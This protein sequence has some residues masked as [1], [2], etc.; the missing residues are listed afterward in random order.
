MRILHILEELKPS[1]AE[2]MLHAA[3]PY[4]RE[5]G[6]Q[7]DILS[8][9]TVP[10]VY[11]Q[12]LEHAGYQIHHIPFTP[13]YAFL[14]AVY[15]FLRQRRYD[16]VH[17]HLERANFWYALLAYSSGTTKVAYTIH[18]IFP[19]NGALRIERSVQRWLM[20]NVI[21]VEMVTVSLSGERRERERFGN[22][23]SVI[24][25]WFE[26]TKYKLPSPKER[27]VSRAG[28]GIASD[29]T[30]VTSIGGC[31]SY[32]NH[33]SIVE[34]I[35]RLPMSVPLVYLHVGQEQEGYPE[36]QFAAEIGVSARVRFLGIVSDVLP[37]LHASDV[38]IMPST[39]EAFGVAA[40]EAMGAGLPAILS[41]VP[42]LCDFRNAGEGICWVKPTP[43]SIARGIL[44]LLDVPVSERRRMGANLSSY[45]HEH[46]GVE[47]GAAAYARLYE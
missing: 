29:V 22:K 5:Q 28:L 11:A 24:P 39:Y 45:A 37:I 3:A 15:R 41:D 4:W 36:R 31:W 17:I 44:H 10:G 47:W 46:F 7:C 43:D 21:G 25:N 30:I 6:L 19:F 12:V 42:G 35:A 13:S 16:A 34:A 33:R 38:Y 1:G 23:T 14:R 40:V 27:H 26:N 32:K 8:V 2:V 18:G 20:R 9:G